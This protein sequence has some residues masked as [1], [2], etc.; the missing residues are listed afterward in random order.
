MSPVSSEDRPS[1]PSLPSWLLATLAVC[2]QAST[3]WPKMYL[4][5]LTRA[6]QRKETFITLLADALGQ[7]AG[8]GKVVGKGGK[9]KGV[10]ATAGKVRKL[11]NEL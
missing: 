1:A 6:S 7:G 10:S 3:P 5:G 2:L 4:S 9:R 11:S 8:L